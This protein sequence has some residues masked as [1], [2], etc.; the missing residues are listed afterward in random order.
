MNAF[1]EAFRDINRRV[2]FETYFSYMLTADPTLRLTA[3]EHLPER[4]LEALL[5]CHSARRHGQIL[6]SRERR[7]LFGAFFEWEQEAVVQPAVAAAFAALNWPE[8]AWAAR[9]PAI[10]FSYLPVMEP[11]LFANFG[12]PQ[13]RLAKGYEAF[14]QGQRRGWSEVEHDLLR[15]EGLPRSFRPDC[16]AHFQNLRRAAL[17]WIDGQELLLSA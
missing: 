10:R 14:D 9:R 6:T 16:S 2:C 13:E 7:E 11:L 1:A 17:I 4:L 12:C 15:Y 5:R 8:I 3:G